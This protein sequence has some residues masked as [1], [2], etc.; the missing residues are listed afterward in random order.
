MGGGGYPRGGRERRPDVDLDVAVD[1]AVDVDVDLNFDLDLDF[2]F[3]FDGRVEVEVQVE[4]EVEVED[5]VHVHVT[6]YPRTPIDRYSPS[7]SLATDGQAWRCAVSRPR[8]PYAAARTGSR[9]SRTRARAHAPGIVR[10]RA[11]PPRAR[12]SATSR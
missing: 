10:L 12:G 7:T 5:H 2:D 4:V 9:E 3:D 6:R 11:A 8:S 1:L